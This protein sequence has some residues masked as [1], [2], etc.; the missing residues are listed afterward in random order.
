MFSSAND[1]STLG[2]AILGSRLIKP[3]LTRRWLQPTAYT[4]DIRAAV[5]IPWG[6]RRIP[7]SDTNPHRTIT[8][9]NK[10]GE[11]RH[12]G[13]ILS[14]LPDWDIGFTILR[15]GNDTGGSGFGFADLIGA[16]LIPAFDAATRRSADAL[17]SG[18]YA[19]REEGGGGGGDGDGGSGE[20]GGGVPAL[21]SSLVVSTDPSKPGL[22]VGPWISNG[23]NMMNVVLQLQSGNPYAAVA[24]AA[25]LYWTGLETVADDGSRRQSF[26]AVFEDEG[27]PFPNKTGM[28]S[29]TCAAWLSQSGV[30][31]GSL[32]L[33]EFVFEVNPEGKVVSVENLALRAKLYKIS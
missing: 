6:L 29:T 16:S 25:R 14:L 8:S 2:L 21:N 30:T 4:A 15:A 27:L 23:I 10:G 11:I 9:F 19:A 13:A 1:I 28:F 24:P 32:P 12:Y 22:G 18:E 5:G 3:S 20:D 33:D 7:L 26:K 31:Y 17:Y